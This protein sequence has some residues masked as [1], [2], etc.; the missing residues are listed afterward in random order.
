M[1]FGGGTSTETSTTVPTGGI[2]LADSGN[3]SGSSYP[4]PEV[5]LSPV[6][7]AE[8]GTR[9]FYQCDSKS[10]Y[11]G[12]H[13]YSK[14][15]IDPNDPSKVTKT[16]L[17]GDE[18]KAAQLAFRALSGLSETS[19]ADEVAPLVPQNAD[20]G[21]Y[22]TLIDAA[23]YDNRVYVL[24][25]AL[26]SSANTAK[27]LSVFAQDGTLLARKELGNTGHS[28]ARLTI[29]PTGCVAATFFGAF[30]DDRNQ[31]ELTRFFDA[32][33]NDHGVLATHGMGT[34]C[35]LEDGRF[36]SYGWCYNA[37]FAEGASIADPR[38]ALCYDITKPFAA[39]DKPKQNDDG[40][41]EHDTVP[42]DPKQ[43]TKPTDPPKS[44]TPQADN[45]NRKPAVQA[46]QPKA[47]ASLPRTG[48]DRPCAAVF[49]VAG[50]VA[51]V[52]A[53]ATRERNA[54]AS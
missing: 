9:Y 34:S 35:W 20:L 51:L 25:E 8:D 44:P 52:A 49:A 11:F 23:V 18:A 32:D 28:H 48:D 31:Q 54:S 6:F 4:P 40:E 21:T 36:I 22:D 47:Q 7:T 45:K 43:P 5:S 13:E 39:A 50:L 2:P 17:D 3:V 24:S 53:F 42:T 10:P 16:A 46:A 30:F 12:S 19:R 27:G 26:G 14:N 29:G 41:T 37:N 33:L 1:L 15:V 38:F